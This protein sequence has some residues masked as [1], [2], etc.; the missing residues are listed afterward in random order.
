M[1]ARET[2]GKTGR[3][4]GFLPT[5][6][7]LHLFY[8]H[9]VAR[10][11]D[12]FLSRHQCRVDRRVYT[13]PGIV[14]EYKTWRERTTT[15]GHAPQPCFSELVSCNSIARPARRPL[16][17]P[18]PFSPPP[19]H[20][21]NRH[22]QTWRSETGPMPFL[23]RRLRRSRWESAAHVPPS[24]FLLKAARRGR[25][26]KGFFEGQREAAGPPAVVCGTGLAHGRPVAYHWE[27]LQRGGVSG[28]KE[29]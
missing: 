25:K 21:F 5:G 2:K 23:K 17:S 19:L 12:V 27:T 10:N 3:H 20:P 7:P 14:G 15:T 11:R 16:S 28:G 26:L 8:R 24:V 4:G 22:R 13:I 6:V 29:R 9:E 18:F 1:E